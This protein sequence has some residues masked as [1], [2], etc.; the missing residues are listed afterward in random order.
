MR[1]IA[2]K[3]PAARNHSGFS[4]ASTQAEMAHKN[5][6]AVGT[7]LIARAAYLMK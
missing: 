5:R 2:V 3:A 4:S 7:S 1:A 6:N